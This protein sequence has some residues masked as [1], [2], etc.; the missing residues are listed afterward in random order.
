MKPGIILGVDGGGSKTHLAL[1][2]SDGRLLAMESGPGTNLESQKASVISA[3]LSGLLERACQKAHVRLRDIA[4]SCFGLCGVDIAE[5]ISAARNIISVG[6]G[7]AGPVKIHN[8]AFIALF[9]DGWR[10]RGGVV[11]V[12]TG[13][14]WLAVSGEKE[15]MHDGLV[16]PGL[17]DMVMEELL[18]EAEGY[19]KPS[20][21]TRRMFRRLG[22]HSSADFIRRWRYGASRAYVRPVSAGSWSR[23]A[24]VQELL[25]REANSG[26]FVARS[27]INRYAARLAEGA[28][29]AVR[30]VGASGRG[31]EVVMSGSVL[32]G[33]APLRLAFRRQLAKTLPGAVA[34]PARFR[35]ICG[36]LVYAA[37]LAGGDISRNT[38]AEK[39]LRY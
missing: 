36:A 23:I 11:T 13:Q 35:P 8:D 32:A 12:G 3:I 20:G 33:I 25:G 10:A 30:R 19:T 6:M 31:L 18:M 16:I 2:S 17:K 26:D 15:F 14:K 7:L 5:D 24:R 4:A 39:A 37:H 28:A 21:F 29:V 38:L 22:F 9:N 34:V 1:A 27:I